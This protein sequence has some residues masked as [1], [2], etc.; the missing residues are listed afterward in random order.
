MT[1]FGRL[2]EDLARQQI[3][4]RIAEAERRRTPGPRRPH[5]RHAFARRLHRLADRLDT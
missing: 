2:T 1:D 5:G 3:A 4:D